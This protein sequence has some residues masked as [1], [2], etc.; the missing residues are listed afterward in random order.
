MK[1]ERIIHGACCLRCAVGPACFLCCGVACADGEAYCLCYYRGLLPVLLSVPFKRP[2][3]WAFFLCCWRAPLSV[4]LERPVVS[5]IFY[6]VRNACFMSCH[7]LH[8]AVNTGESR[9]EALQF[10]SVPG[11]KVISSPQPFFTAS[12]YLDMC[13]LKITPHIF[14]LKYL[15]SGTTEKLFRCG[16]VVPRLPAAGVVMAG[17]WPGWD[18]SG[19]SYFTAPF[20]SS[21]TQTR[22]LHKDQEIN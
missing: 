21:I 17:Y 10:Y 15:H 14:L 19:Q 18:Y 1:E 8:P 6:A 3:V 13:L 12:L 2:V 7:R 9:Q 5:A 22:P 11:D 20:V 4:L 16:K